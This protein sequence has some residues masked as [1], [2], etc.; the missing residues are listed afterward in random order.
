MPHGGD[1]PSIRAETPPRGWGGGAPPLD[2][3]RARDD[4]H[5]HWQRPWRR[6]PRLNDRH[7]C[8]CDGEGVGW[9]PQLAAEWRAIPGLVPQEWD[10]RRGRG[11]QG[12]CGSGTRARPAARA[13]T[14]VDLELTYANRG[15]GA[16]VGIQQDVARAQRIEAG[17]LVPA[18][19]AAVGVEGHPGIAVPGVQRPLGGVHAGRPADDG[20]VDVVGGAQVHVDPRR[21]GRGRAPLGVQVGI[22]GVAGRVAGQLVERQARL[23][24]GHVAAAAGPG[25]TPVPKIS[26]SCSS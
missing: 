10:G 3:I 23:A 17:R 15:P 4:R 6:R 9:Q 24:G 16:P 25:A 8:G 26:H 12:G 14:G 1:Q 7:V 5:R 21:R 13:A 20:L 2:T 11:W 19:A 22:E 18:G